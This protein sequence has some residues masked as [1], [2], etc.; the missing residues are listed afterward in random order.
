MA[1]NMEAVTL[2]KN[3]YQIS[4]RVKTLLVLAP[5][6]CN[7]KRAPSLYV[8]YTIVIERRCSKKRVSFVFPLK[9]P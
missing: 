7:G 2:K 5:V 6:K 4:V 3:E 1:T 9:Y 8:A